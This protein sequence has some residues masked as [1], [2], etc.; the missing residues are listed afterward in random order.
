MFTCQVPVL[1]V[2]ETAVDELL[3][4]AFKATTVFPPSP[5]ASKEIVFPEAFAVTVSVA[6]P[7]VGSTVTVR[8]EVFVQAALAAVS[9]LFCWA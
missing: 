5:D 3:G 8:H 9:T 6:P 4:V 7:C 1:V 2:D